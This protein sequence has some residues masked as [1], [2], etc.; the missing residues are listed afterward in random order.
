MYLT[1]KSLAYGCQPKK[2]QSVFICEVVLFFNT[3]C[4]FLLYLTSLCFSYFFMLTITPLIKLS[5]ENRMFQQ[6][7]VFTGYSSI[8]FLVH[9]PFPNTVNEATLS[10]LQVT[11]QHL[12]IGHHVAPLITRYFLLNTYIEKQRISLVMASILNMCLCPHT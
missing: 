1:Q 10:A 11:M 5:Y 12:C 4:C 6:P 9:P 8:Q 2:H 7:L 3:L